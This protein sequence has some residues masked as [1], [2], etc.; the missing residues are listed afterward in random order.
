[1]VI[2]GIDYSLTCPAICIHDSHDGVFN[3]DNAHFYCGDLKD[4][5]DSD[6]MSDIEKPNIVIVDPPRPGLH[7]K[8]I[9]NLIKL[10]PEKIIYVSCN[11]ATMA[12]DIEILASEKYMIKDLQPIDMFPHTPH[13]ECIITLIKK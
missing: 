5:L 3:F 13:I 1:M 12:R 6:I 8:T 10:L 2:A 7:P 11:P 9:K 4:V